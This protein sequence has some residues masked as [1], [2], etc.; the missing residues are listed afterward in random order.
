[1]KISIKQKVSEDLALRDS[2]N[3]FFDDL[4]KL[5]NDSI[6]VSFAGVKTISRSFAHQYLTRKSKSSKEITEE[7]VPKLVSQMFEAVEN[8]SEKYKLPKLTAHK[9]S[10]IEA[11]LAQS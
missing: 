9:L 6:A 4:E 11:A 10:T 5:R 8:P 2:A 3:R 7:N 1:M